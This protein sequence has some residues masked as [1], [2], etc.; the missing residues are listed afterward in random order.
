MPETMSVV[1]WIVVGLLTGL[2]AERLGRS[3]NFG[4]VANLVVGIIGALGGGYLARSLDVGV[5]GLIASNIS[6]WIGAV[7]LLFVLDLLLGRR[8]A[9]RR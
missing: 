2:L 6:A 5:I 3:H 8:P 7:V 9:V 1:S 4:L